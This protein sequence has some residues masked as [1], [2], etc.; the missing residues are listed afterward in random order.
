MNKN[1]I[2]TVVFALLILLG[3]LFSVFSL[4]ASPQVAPSPPPLPTDLA[5]KRIVPTLVNLIK[6][7]E[8]ESSLS[9]ALIARL[10][11]K[12]KGRAVFRNIDVEDEPE[13]ARVYN[14]RSLPTIIIMNPTGRIIYRHEGYVDEEIIID[15]LKA[16]GME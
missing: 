13:M 11:D 15:K 9:L 8:R 14:V 2:I 5:E 6:E 10:E 12:Y 1:V 3:G 16:A 4:L 7:G